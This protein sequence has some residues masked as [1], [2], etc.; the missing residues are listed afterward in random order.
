MSRG[1][2]LWSFGEGRFWR[3]ARGAPESLEPPWRE[4]KEPR[5]RGNLKSLCVRGDPLPGR[6]SGRAGAGPG[7]CARERFLAPTS[8]AASPPESPR[9]GRAVSAYKRRALPH[10]S[11]PIGCAPICLALIGPSTRPSAAAAARHWAGVC[12]RGTCRLTGEA[13]PPARPPRADWIAGPVRPPPP[14]H[15]IGRKPVGVAK[16]DR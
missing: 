16:T 7:C 12:G 5:P 4:R 2:T 14:P 9:A 1:A 3:G 8:S 10:P 15:A 6:A 13:T 11:P